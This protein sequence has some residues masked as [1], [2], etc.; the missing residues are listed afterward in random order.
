MFRRREM[1]LIEVTT[2]ENE[3]STEQSEELISRLTDAVTKVTSDKLRDATWV[4]I[5]T[6]KSGVWGIGG[7]ALGLAD[8]RKLTGA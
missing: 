7:K 1:P 4:I 5:R 6:V 8:V 3:L 2:F